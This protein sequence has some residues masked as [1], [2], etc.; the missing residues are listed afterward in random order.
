MKVRVNLLMCMCGSV[1]SRE[2]TLFRTQRWA[3]AVD[4]SVDIETPFMR[5][6]ATV[7]I[8]TVEVAARR[9]WLAM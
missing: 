8:N 5:S 2:G 3:S 9:D 4:Q 6:K 1:V 7:M